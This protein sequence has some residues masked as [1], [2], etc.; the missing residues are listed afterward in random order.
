MYILC[1]NTERL[2]LAR[3]ASQTRPAFQKPDDSR[4]RREMG[5]DWRHLSGNLA[6]VPEERDKSLGWRERQSCD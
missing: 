2:T 6:V 1:G 5:G 4:L 3:S